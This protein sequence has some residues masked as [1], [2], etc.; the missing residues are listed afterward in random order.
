MSKANQAFNNNDEAVSPVIGV[1]LMVAITVVLAAVVF[2]LVSN[3]G[4]TSESA[5]DISFSADESDNEIRVVK[6]ENGLDWADFDITGS[7]TLPTGTVE[8]GDVIDCAD[9]ANEN[10][11]IRHVET[12]SV[13]YEHEFATS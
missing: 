2:V 9:S 3:L 13:V 11:V 6:A 5:P 7:C 1:I 12:N 10:I 4:D 8:A